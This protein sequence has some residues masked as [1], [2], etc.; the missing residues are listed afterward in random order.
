MAA[1]S[2]GVNCE[3]F[4]EFQAPSNR[5]GHSG[6]LRGGKAELGRV[7]SDCNNL[8]AIHRNLY[9]AC[10][11]LVLEGDRN[12]NERESLIDQLPPAGPLLEIKP[13]TRAC[14][15]NRN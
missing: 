5:T 14:A 2:G 11:I 3:E 10:A 13:V 4:A 1:P 6:W 7:G 8:L 12:I 9:L 15:L